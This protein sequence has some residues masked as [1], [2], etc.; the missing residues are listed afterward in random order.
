ML[1]FLKPY[2]EQ[3]VAAQAA[4]N[5]VALLILFWMIIKITSLTRLVFAIK[6][7]FKEPE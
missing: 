2:L 4:F 3:S 7:H 6:H 1:L 5:A